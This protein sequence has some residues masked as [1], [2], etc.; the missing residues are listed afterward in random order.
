M[1]ETTVILKVLETTGPCPP[2]WDTMMLVIGVI[3]EYPDIAGISGGGTVGSVG[4]IMVLP[5][6]IGLGKGFVG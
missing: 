1:N 6:T 3:E 4:R 2:T 5:N